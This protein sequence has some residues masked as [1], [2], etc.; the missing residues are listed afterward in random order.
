MKW[1]TKI[2]INWV[3]KELKKDKGY[4]MA[5]QA[6]IAMSF[7]DEVTKINPYKPIGKINWHDVSNNAAKN[8]LQL[9][10]RES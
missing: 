4:W 7:Y 2:A 1:I 9:L 3:I 10:T 5:F 8:F 6:N